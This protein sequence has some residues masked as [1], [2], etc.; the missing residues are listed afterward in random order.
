M[1]FAVSFM[2]MADEFDKIERRLMG[3]VSAIFLQ[4]IPLLLFSHSN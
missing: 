1:E 4:S 3:V 2:G